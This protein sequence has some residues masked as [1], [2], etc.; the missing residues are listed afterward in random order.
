MYIH[1]DVHTHM[2][3][4][5]HVSTRVYT[6]M[7]YTRNLRRHMLCSHEWPADLP[8][9]FHLKGDQPAPGR[10]AAPQHLLCWVL[11]GPTHKAQSPQSLYSLGAL[12]RSAGLG[13]SSVCLSVGCIFVQCVRRR[14]CE[15]GLRL[16]PGLGCGECGRFAS[17]HP[18]L[19]A[20]SGWAGGRP[21]SAVRSAGLDPQPRCT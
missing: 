2:L 17:T 16:D 12:E 18:P 8:C 3:M 15:M 21:W 9:T 10:A 13:G 14:V 6:H 7:H 19:P 4:Y 20:R 11:C 1:T 5:I